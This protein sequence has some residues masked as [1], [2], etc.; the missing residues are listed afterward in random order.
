MRPV[1]SNN[2]GIG[3]KRDKNDRR[4][5]ALIR[6]GRL[7]SRSARTQRAAVVYNSLKSHCF[8]RL[9]DLYGKPSGDNVHVLVPCAACGSF[10]LFDQMDLDHIHGR[11]GHQAGE[12][13]RFLDPTNWQ[14]LCRLCHIVKTD[15]GPVDYAAV[16][17]PDW[18]RDMVA[19]RDSVIYQLPPT[20]PSWSRTQILEAFNKVLDVVTVATCAECGSLKC[21]CQDDGEEPED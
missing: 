1:K 14:F 7:R 9:V 5:V 3:G 21:E 16:S 2:C 15:D 4:R 10:M 6:R 11:H 13:D 8:S 19:L 20:P 18:K 12:L 17:L